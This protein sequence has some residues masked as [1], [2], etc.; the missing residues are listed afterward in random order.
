M[1]IKVKDEEGQAVV[2][3]ALAMSIFLIGAVGLAVDGS[4]LY[5][6]RQMAQTAADAAAIGGMMSIFNGT[7]VSGTAAFTPITQGTSFLCSSKPNSTPC[8]YA[9]KDGFTPTGDIVTVSFPTDGAAPG[10]A[11]A[12]DATHLIQVTVQRSVTTT[13]M[14][15]LGPTATTVQATAMAAIVSVTSPVPILVTHPTLTQSLSLQGTPSIK[16]CGGP[17]RSIQVNS[18]DGTALHSQGSASIDLSKAGPPDTGDCMTGTG[19]DLGVWGGPGTSPVGVSLGSTGHYV[20]PASPIQ[21]PLANVLPPAV[22]TNSGAMG[23]STPLAPGV[24]GCPVS[25][26]KGCQLYNP[27]LWVGGIDGKLSTPIFKPGI[28]Y[29]QGGGMTCA[30]LCDMYMATGFTDTGANTTNTGWTGNM[31]VYNTGATGTP[32]NAG[33]FNLG[34]NGNISLVGSPTSSLYK[35]I[36][37]FQ[38]HNSVAQSHSLGGGGSLS[39]VGTLYLTNTLATMTSTPTQYQTVQISGH[40]GS[41]TLIQGEIIVSALTLGGNGGIEMDLNSLAIYTIRQVSLVQ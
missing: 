5:S 33:A 25:P 19:A 30:A 11:F 20:E 38:D 14:R 6:Q 21:D 40:G 9:S 10:V 39:L 34:A 16:I 4:H 32:T 17:N 3:V 36:L 2:L 1:N 23:T 35:G 41:S 12:A 24:S 31:L 37:F 26:R 8:A 27:G 13:L 18:S 15:F 7:N 29:I 28:Y 22:P